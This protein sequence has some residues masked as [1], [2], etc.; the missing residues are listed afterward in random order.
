M[1]VRWLVL[2]FAFSLK[3]TKKSTSP[4]HYFVRQKWSIS[5]HHVCQINNI[6]S[7]PF[8]LVVSAAALL[9]GLLLR[10]LMIFFFGWKLTFYVESDC[11][12][13]SKGFFFGILIN[14]VCKGFLWN[15]SL[16]ISPISADC[17]LV[18]CVR[19]CYD[20]FGLSL[21]WCFGGCGQ[22]AT[23]TAAQFVLVL[24]P[25]AVTNREEVPASLLVHVPHVRFLT[26]V[27]GVRFVD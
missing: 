27:L 23:A 20:L 24:F 15:M 7:F 6:V 3:E 16:K 25:E 9:N 10:S 18:G 2:S 22:L 12:F 17:L 1:C 14:I 19:L 5:Y 8:R 4:R 21:W 11:G 13:R 26:G